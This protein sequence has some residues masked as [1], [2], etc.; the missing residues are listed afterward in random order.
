M[1]AREKLPS[2]ARETASRPVLA[3]E[4]SK[5]PFLCFDASLPLWKLLKP[6]TRF[7]S[8]LGAGGGVD[9]TSRRSR[10]ASLMERT[11]WCGQEI[12]GP[13]HPVCTN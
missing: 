12:P 10:E 11:G 9:A 3:E 1:R 4:L 13:H 8:S 6:L 5:V 7:S 2:S